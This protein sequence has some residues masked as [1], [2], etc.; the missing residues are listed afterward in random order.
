MVKGWIDNPASKIVSS[1]KLEG[2]DN[3]KTHFMNLRAKEEPMGS[4]SGLSNVLPKRMS[5]A[6]YGFRKRPVI[7]S[8]SR[9]GIPKQTTGI[10]REKS[11]IPPPRLLRAA[12]RCRE[13]EWRARD[14][15]CT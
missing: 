10:K 7:K 12:Q 1:S 11:G 4:L 15:P 9:I 2:D 5:S 6:E 8:I 3:E 13:R 14:S